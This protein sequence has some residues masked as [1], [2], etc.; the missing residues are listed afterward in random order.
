MVGEGAGF[1][2]H[3]RRGKKPGEG[4]TSTAVLSAESARAS[5][6]PFIVKKLCLRGWRDVQGGEAPEKLASNL[7]GWVFPWNL[8]GDGLR[9]GRPGDFDWVFLYSDKG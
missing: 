7:S 1:K 9:T 2:V 3:L 8:T 5:E 4:V 6:G